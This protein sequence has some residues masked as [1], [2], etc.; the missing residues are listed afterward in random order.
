[1]DLMQL[2]I[3]AASGALA[4]QVS[5]A[6]VRNDAL[7][8]LGNILTGGLGGAFGGQ[9]LGSLLGLGAGLQGVGIDASEIINGFATGGISGA[10]TAMVLAY[11]KSKLIS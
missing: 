1:M 5:N 7:G 10:L 6:A 3:G 4:G 9:L 2:L 8:T 11:L